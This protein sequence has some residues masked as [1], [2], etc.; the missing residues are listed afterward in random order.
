LFSRRRAFDRTRYGPSPVAKVAIGHAVAAERQRFE[1]RVAHEP[2]SVWRGRV[3]DNRISMDRKPRRRI[4][5]CAVPG[6]VSLC[7]N[8]LLEKL[9]TQFSRRL[10]EPII[11][12][13][14]PMFLHQGRERY[15]RTMGVAWFLAAPASCSTT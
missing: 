10:V 11:H 2:L 12:D 5:W 6:A 1:R 14:H 9:I 8:E 4:A 7:L 13:E 3:S 15:S